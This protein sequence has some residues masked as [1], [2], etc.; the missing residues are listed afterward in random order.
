[1]GH[2]DSAWTSLDNV[3]RAEP[4]LQRQRGR[5][6]ERNSCRNPWF[7]TVNARVTKAIP[8]RAGESVELTADVY[9]VLNLI[10]SQWGQ[11]RITIRDPFVQTLQLVGYD[12]TAGRGVYDYVFRGARR[13]QDLE[14]R[15]QMQLGLRYAF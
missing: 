13:I 8:T 6:L 4:C 9:N 14:S 10:N 5:V 12:A 15:W 7:G 11:Y 2:Q 3:I 1:V